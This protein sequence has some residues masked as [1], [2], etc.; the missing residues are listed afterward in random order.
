MWKKKST[1]IKNCT[2][3]K[4]STKLNFQLHQLSRNKFGNKQ[5]D[6]K[7]KVKKKNLDDVLYLPNLCSMRAA[8]VLWSQLQ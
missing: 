4:K 3:Q 5:I 8:E 2:S 6:K 7:K 1:V